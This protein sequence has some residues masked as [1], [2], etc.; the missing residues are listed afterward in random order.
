VKNQAAPKFS[1]QQII[2][3]LKIA[4]VQKDVLRTVLRDDETYTLDQARR[5][6]KEFA[7]RKVN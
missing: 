3:S 4:P 7:S 1:K 2:R 5:L 6:I